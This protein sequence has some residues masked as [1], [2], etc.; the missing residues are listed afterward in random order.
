MMIL[1]TL[2]VISTLA[3]VWIAALLQNLVAEVR[4][5]RKDLQAAAS[6]PMATHQLMLTIRDQYFPLKH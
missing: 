5:L 4:L 6:W 2:S 3:L 1:I